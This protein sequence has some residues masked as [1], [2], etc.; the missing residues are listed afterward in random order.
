MKRIATV[1]ATRRA[2]K[3]PENYVPRN[4]ADKQL[5][6]A[7]PA[8]VFLCGAIAA[9]IQLR[10]DAGLP[11]VPNPAEVQSCMDRVTA[12][13]NGIDA[14][15]LDA[16][17]AGAALVAAVQHVVESRGGRMSQGSVALN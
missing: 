9:V 16:R 17:K 7:S 14:G 1:Q 10:S 5:G 2:P 12:I 4:I 13:C 11:L 8:A 15:D 6:E 3:R